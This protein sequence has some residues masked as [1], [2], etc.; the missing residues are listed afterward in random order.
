MKRAVYYSFGSLVLQELPIF[1]E[2]SIILVPPNNVG[3][4]IGSMRLLRKR[5]RALPDSKLLILL[6]SPKR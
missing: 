5:I 3:I 4:N 2:N 6:K 1:R